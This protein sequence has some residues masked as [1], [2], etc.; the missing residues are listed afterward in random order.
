MKLGVQIVR[1]DVENAEIET[2]DGIVW[3]GDILIGADGL[4]CCVRKATLSTNDEMEEEEVSEDDGWDI[5]RWLLD[6]KIIEEDSELKALFRQGRQTF[7][8]PHQGKT[9]RLVWYSYRDGELQNLAAFCLAKLGESDREDYDASAD[10]DNLL[11]RF[12]AYH[13]TLLKL[14]KAAD[15]IKSWRLRNRTPL[16]TYVYGKTLLIGDAAHPMLP[17]NAQGGNQTLQDCGALFALF[18]SL[19]EKKSPI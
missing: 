4:H 12:S 17:F 18:S 6:T 10:K 2:D 19:P 11:K 7:V 1:V 16:S 3:K 8:Y 9:F 13:P 14:M 15:A 5:F